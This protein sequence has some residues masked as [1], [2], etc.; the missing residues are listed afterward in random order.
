LT[1]LDAYALVALVADEPAADEV[2]ALLRGGGCR[3]VIANLAE[4]IDRCS[5][6]HGIL[7][8]DVRAVLEPLLGD[9]LVPAVSAEREA[10]QAAELHSLHYHRR[11]SPLSLADCFLLAHAELSDDRIATADLP[12][13][14]IARTRGVEVVPLPDSSG[15]RP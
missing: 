10:W 1:L 4:A 11:T 15:R 2:E 14:G 3:V 12:L 6:V 5:R 13:A 8:I 7:T 9:G